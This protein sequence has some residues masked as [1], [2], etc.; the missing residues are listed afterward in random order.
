MTRA[1][2]ATIAVLMLGGSGLAAASALGV[3]ETITTSPQCCSFS[4]PTFTIDAG[5]VATFNNPDSASHN[6]TATTQ[7][8]DGKELFVSPTVSGGQTQVNGTQYLQPGSYD[9][10]C[11]IHPGMTATLQVGAGTP[12][13]RPAVTL[14]ILSSKIDK[15][16]S[17]RTLKVKLS[18]AA[19][20]DGVSLLARKGARRIG[21]KKVDVAAGTSETAKLHLSGA[22]KHAL[23]DLGAAKVSVTATVPFG[24]PAS[25]KRKLH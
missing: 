12:L 10:M 13:A 25:A 17:S 4:Q 5:Q 21:S 2:R 6:V 18:A 8:P 9:F 3:T 22:G 7:G 15:V 23:E 19:E 16:V 20:S 1:G 14:K 11:T 24:S